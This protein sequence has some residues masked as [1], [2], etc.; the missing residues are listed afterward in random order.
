MLGRPNRVVYSCA[1]FR[2]E[3]PFFQDDKYGFDE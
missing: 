3:H 1:L 2:I